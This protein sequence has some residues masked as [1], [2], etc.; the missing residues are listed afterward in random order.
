MNLAFYRDS[1]GQH[2]VGPTLYHAASR[3]V[4]RV[5]RVSVWHA[6]VVTRSKVDPAFMAESV[7]P[8]RVVGRVL[9]AAEVRR[10][11]GSPANGLTASFLDDAEAAGSLCYAFLDGESLASFTWYA[12]RPT[13]LAEVSAAH[14]IQFDSA[15]LYTYHAFTEPRYRGHRLHALGMCAALD[16][17]AKNR[18]GLLA[19]VDSS[20][21]GSLKSFARLGSQVFGHIAVLGVGGATLFVPSAGCLAHQFRVTK[22]AS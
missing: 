19:Y 6:M 2:G 20:N 22:V 9:E 11:A 10:Y 7:L 13:R 14:E 18:E 8:P 4:N 16:G 3:A 17:I 12:W 1:L 5:A 21:L 15:F